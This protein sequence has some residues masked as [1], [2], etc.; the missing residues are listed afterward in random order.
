MI[1]NLDVDPEAFQAALN[2]RIGEPDGQLPWLAESIVAELLTLSLQP[3]VVSGHVLASRTLPYRHYKPTSLIQAS[4]EGILL[5]YLKLQVD[6]PK[7]RVLSQTD[8]GLPPHLTLHPI[9]YANEGRTVKF[10]RQSMKTR[11]RYHIELLNPSIPARLFASA[12][13][14]HRCGSS[15]GRSLLDAAIDGVWDWKLRFVCR[16]C[17]RAFHC[18]CFERAIRGLSTDGAKADPRIEFLP[19]LCHLCTGKPSNLEFCHPMYGSSVLVRYGPYIR[20]LE[21][22]EGLLQRD[23]ENRVRELLG[24]PKI[25][26]GWISDAALS[27]RG[28]P[29]QRLCGGA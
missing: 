14:L 8:F 27:A 16:V 12:A 18:S 4:A 15:C 2:R 20:K 29:A 5:W 13:A 23:A 28:P 6:T 25:G 11:E 26:E 19:K 3:L 10:R 21:H 9:R 22:E 1:I 24:I 17:G 7:T